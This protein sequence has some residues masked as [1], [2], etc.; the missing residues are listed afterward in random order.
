[1]NLS[2][3]IYLCFFCIADIW[4]F[5]IKNAENRYFCATRAEFKSNSNE[6]RFF[7][8][9]RDEK[10]IKSFQILL[11]VW[12]LL[13]E[14]QRQ[15]K[16]IKMWWFDVIRTLFR[17]RISFTLNF[18]FVFRI[19]F[20]ISFN[21]ITKETTTTK[22]WKTKI[23]SVKTKATWKIFRIVLLAKAF[24]KNLKIKLIAKKETMK[25]SEKVLSK[26][27]NDSQKLRSFVK[28]TKKLTTTLKDERL[29]DWWFDIFRI[30][31]KVNKNL[32]MRKYIKRF[33]IIFKKKTEKCFIHDNF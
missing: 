9:V 22:T 2:K 18:F 20:N 15:R 17:K 31:H 14:W 12:F 10:I 8:Y 7:I 28:A 23:F 1:M 29:F 11:I 16:S 13:I 27:L 3:H 25:Y 5:R 30:Y 26:L 19:N 6:H 24:K 21:A 32:L 33:M 4:C